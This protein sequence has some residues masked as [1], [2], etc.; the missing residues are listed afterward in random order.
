MTTAMHGPGTAAI[1]R[2]GG[3][4]RAA[5]IIAA[6]IAALVVA[7]MLDQQAYRL[8]SVHDLHSRQMLES[9][10]WYRL[11]R[12]LGSLWTWGGVGVVL[13][14][15]D[16]SRVRRG[17]VIRGGWPRRGVVVFTSALLSGAAAEGIK[18]LVG[19]YRPENTDGA[20]VFMTVAERLRGQWS[21]LGM[22]SS[23]AAVAFGAAMALSLKYRAAAP[24]FLLAAAGCGLT[25]V[26]TVQHFVSDVVAAAAVAYAVTLAVWR[27][28]AW[29]NRGVAWVEP[30][31]EGKAREGGG[32]R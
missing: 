25:R 2:G 19:R 16:R 26:M 12:V 18:A 32:S 23:H 27:V 13:L 8:L 21:D 15:I 20:Y 29:N 9:Q 4:A 7:T 28:D 24:V 31:W 5:L 6:W 1:A 17:A 30:G 22:P 3:W 14:L 10:D 11:L